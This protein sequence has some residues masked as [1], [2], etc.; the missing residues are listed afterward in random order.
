MSTPNCGHE[1]V[2]SG[3]KLY[4]CAGDGYYRAADGAVLFGSMAGKANY[5]KDQL[6]STCLRA[7]AAAAVGVAV[8][9]VLT[10]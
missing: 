7:A 9:H 1:S 4:T 8:V 3:G 6:V 2:T 10:R 5:E